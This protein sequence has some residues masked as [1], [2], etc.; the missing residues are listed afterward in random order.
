MLGLEVGVGL[1][2]WG[3]AVRVVGEEVVLDIFGF[4]TKIEM[5][6]RRKEKQ[7]KQRK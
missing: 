2:F 4:D 7:R 5:H 3:F 1:I 6:V